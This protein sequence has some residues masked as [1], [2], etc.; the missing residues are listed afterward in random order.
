MRKMIPAV[1][2]NR[3]RNWQNLFE[4]A[5]VNMVVCKIWLKMPFL[6]PEPTLSPLYHNSSYLCET[7]FKVKLVKLLI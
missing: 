4:I 6:A 1:T 2:E 5:S 3:P 7:G